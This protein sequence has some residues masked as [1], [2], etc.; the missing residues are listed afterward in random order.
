MSKPI[1]YAQGA[2]SALLVFLCMPVA[3]QNALADCQSEI[4]RAKAARPAAFSPA[5][6][7]RD[8]RHLAGASCSQLNEV[9]AHLAN[10]EQILKLAPGSEMEKGP[11]AHVR[12]VAC[13][14]RALINWCRLGPNPL[15]SGQAS[16]PNSTSSGNTS[17]TPVPQPAEATRLANK[18]KADADRARQEEIK[19]QKDKTAQYDASWAL[20]R[21]KGAQEVADEKQRGKPKRHRPEGEAHQCLQLKKA[22]L[23]G[24][25]NNTCSAS[26]TY[27]FCHYQPRKDSWGESLDCEKGKIGMGSVKPNTGAAEHTYNSAMIYWFA[28]KDGFNPADAEFV[29]GQGLRGRCIQ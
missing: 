24:G 10:Q 14:Q 1:R 17:N 20:D 5:E 28:C 3:A 8:A 27:Y 22:G 16:I 13:I 25:F 19:R 29:L 9:R 11:M 12:M 18:Q 23:Y 21:A 15:S 4:D 7:D 26:V 2:V 6:I